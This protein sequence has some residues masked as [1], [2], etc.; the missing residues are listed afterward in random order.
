MTTTTKTAGTPVWQQVPPRTVRRGQLWVPGERIEIDG[1]HYQRG[2]MFVEWEAPAEV[3]QPY[4]VVLVHGGTLQGTEWMDTPDG[5][6]GWA[7]RFVEAGYATFVVDRPGHG[8]SPYHSAVVGPMGPP[9][10]HEEGKRVFHPG[11]AT[12]HTQWPIA[13]DDETAAGSFIAA[14]GPMPADLAESERMDADALA[15][16]L[17]LIG[18]AVVVTHSASGPDGWL[19]ADRRPD[20][21]VAVASIEPMG[22]PF[23]DTHGIGRLTWGVT[24]APLSFD[25]PFASGDEVEAAD[26]ETR[27]VPSLAGLPVAVVTAG[28]SPFASFGAPTVEFLRHAGAVA[29]ELHLPDFGIEGNGHGLIYELNSDEAIRPVLAWIAART[30]D[31][32]AR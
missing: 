27:V 29:E 2:Q 31:G 1:S 32:G 13:E 18:P 22:P 28:A 21:V 4:P 10:S 25:P 5:R 23:A 17:D 24:A 14:F 20:Q 8:R 15:N 30:R 7:Q 12:G 11:T 19:L 9:F 16:L 6:P 3:T 26:P